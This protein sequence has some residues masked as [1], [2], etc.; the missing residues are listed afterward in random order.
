MGSLKPH[1]LELPGK[2]RVQRRD[3]ISTLAVRIQWRLRKSYNDILFP[4][5]LLGYRVY[6]SFC[7]FADCFLKDYNL[8]WVPFVWYIDVLIPEKFL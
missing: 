3:S 7:A 4:P 1:K 6:E 5:I 8:Y 2:R